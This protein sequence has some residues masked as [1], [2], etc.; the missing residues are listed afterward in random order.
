MQD[1]ASMG[2]AVGALLKSCGQSV[3]VAESSAGGL[4]SAALLA[5]PGATAYFK[6]GGVVYTGVSKQLLMSLSEAEMV[7]DRAAT[8]PHALRLAAAARARLDADWGIGETGAAGP[9][10]NRYGD[11]PG[12]TCVGISGYVSRTATVETGSDRRVDNMAAFAS[13]ALA[14]LH[15]CV[16][17]A[18]ASS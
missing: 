9:S 2:A 6:G 3:S 1:I 17:E 14:L 8:E 7:A 11:P 10:A 4:I 13:A 18:L 12:H 5:Q 15:T 16:E